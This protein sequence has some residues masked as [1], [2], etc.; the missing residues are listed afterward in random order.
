[1]P[2][3]SHRERLV[4]TVLAQLGEEPPYADN[5]RVGLE[6]RIEVQKLVYLAQEALKLRRMTLGYAD[7]NWYIRGPYSPVLARD[8]YSI[9]R[10]EPADLAT[11]SLREESREAI[12]P[13][14]GLAEATPEGLPK[15]LWLELLASLHYHITRSGIE[16][17]SGG[18]LSAAQINTF[19]CYK[20]NYTPEQVRLAWGALQRGGLLR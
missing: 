2:E 20:R 19:L 7:Y 4:H 1:M 14:S 15:H 13:V 16:V 12:E 8:C 10:L 11:L 18:G 3:P 5:E 17:P 6:R 9:D